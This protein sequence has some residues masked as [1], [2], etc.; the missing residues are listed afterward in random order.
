[1]SNDNPAIKGG[2]CG[3]ILY[4]DLTHS[5]IWDEPITEKLIDEYVGGAGINAKL[6][7]DLVKDNP[8]LDPL[9]PENPLIFG[10]GPI[11]GTAFPC[12]SRYTITSKSPLTGIFGDTNAGGYLPVRFK[13]AG[14]D[15]IVITGKAENPVALLIEPGKK[16]EIVDA[17][18]MWGLD[19]YETDDFIQKKFG[20]S[21]AARIGPAGENLVKYACVMSG[22]KRV[23]CGGRA[24]MGTVM[25][26]KNLKAVIVKDA[27]GTIPSAQTET[28]NEL[29]KKYREIWGKG[30]ETFAHRQYGSFMLINMLRDETSVLNSQAPIS[31]E[32]VENYDINHFVET[33]KTGKNTCNKCPIACTQTWEIKEGPYAGAKGD[34]VEFGHY[35]HL[36]P[37]IGIF[38]FDPLLSLSDRINRLGMDSIQFGW[39]LATT[40]ECYQREILSTDDT[41]GI[42]LK[43]GDAEMVADI[44]EKT[45]RREGFG[46]VLADSMPELAERIGPKAAEY[47]FHT[48]GMTFAYNCES[49]L[50]MALATSV[51]TRGADH[52]KGHPFSGIIGL[53]EMI[54]RI[55]GKDIPEGITESKSPEGKG[56]L[57]WWHENYKMAMDCLGLCFIPLIG[58]T[59]FGDNGMLF[60]EMGEIF[61]AVT[62]QD[63]KRLFKC[64]ERAY[65]LEKAYNA[66]L[67]IDKKDDCRQGT[68]RGKKDPIDLPGM[69]DEYYHYRGCSDQ[70]LPTRKRLQEVDLQDV[71]E[72]L[73]DKGKVADQERPA[74]NE[75]LVK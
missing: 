44:M 11:V 72:N 18:D 9:S 21:E 66:L 20:S 36:G 63:S 5:K 46:D 32:Q 27:K 53:K 28:V 75:L 17:S 65:Q 57:V 38:D 68:K 71:V 34:K 67:G 60:E 47:A 26:S 23:S 37:L 13:Q 10:A 73:A 14:Y 35:N 4:V 6:F 40:M 29:T 15:H 22:T 1:M 12:A 52:L 50:A 41:G 51:G 7:F 43:W 74:I 64:A 58:V 42:A 49:A 69:L 30:S 45:A 8:E 61:E 39:N 55:F 31:D 70:G 33:Y 59:V 54:E 19:T 16:P 2:W 56:R 48:K 25:G 3:K 62:G 24:G